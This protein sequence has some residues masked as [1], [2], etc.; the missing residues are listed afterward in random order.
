MSDVHLTERSGEA[1]QRPSPSQWLPIETAPGVDERRTTTMF[2][3]CAIN[4]SRGFVHGYTSDPWCVWRIANGGFARWPH[5]FPPT[6][7]YPLPE[8]KSEAAV[9]KP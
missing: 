9:Q 2:V 3:V 5:D 7:W 6:H 1:M 4:I 8:R